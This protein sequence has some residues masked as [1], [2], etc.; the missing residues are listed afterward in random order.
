MN[1]KAVVVKSE[2]K[3]VRSQ[4]G[5]LF[6][7]CEGLAKRFNVDPNLMRLIW[8]LSVVLFGTGL[9]LYIVLGLVLPREDDLY[10][11]N[12]PKLLGVCQRLHYRTGVELGILRLLMVLGALFSFGIVFIGYIAAAIFLP[13]RRAAKGASGTF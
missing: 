1:T 10:D 13:D 9:F 3:W 6:G 7:V 11:Y 12:R 4:D 2:D 8:F 5:V